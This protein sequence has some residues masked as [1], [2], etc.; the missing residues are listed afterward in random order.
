MLYFRYCWLISATETRSRVNRCEIFLR[1]LCM[2][3]AIR[4]SNSPTVSKDI[5]VPMISI[6]AYRHVFSRRQP[7]S[8]TFRCMIFKPMD[9]VQEANSIFLLLHWLRNLSLNGHLCCQLWS[10]AVLFKVW[11]ATHRWVARPI[12]RE[13]R[14]IFYTNFPLLMEN[15]Q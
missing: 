7:H 10:K 4:A 1:H 2:E 13:F 6:S 14:N 11:V 15:N 3:L 12:K 5:I 8:V 9:V